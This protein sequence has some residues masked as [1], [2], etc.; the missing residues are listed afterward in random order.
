MELTPTLQSRSGP[1][2]PVYQ[3][4]GGSGRR[5]LEGPK[6]CIPSHSPFNVGTGLWEETGRTKGRDTTEVE[7]FFQR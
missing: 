7:S 4:L 3:E 1:D 2:V 6:Y 5:V